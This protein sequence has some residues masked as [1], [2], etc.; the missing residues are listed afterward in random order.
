MT[1]V[2]YDRAV[3]I[4]QLV[5]VTLPYVDFCPF[6]VYYY[7]SKHLN[8]AHTL[9]CTYQPSCRHLRKSRWLWAKKTSFGFLMKNNVS[10]HEEEGIFVSPFGVVIESLYYV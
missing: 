3:R 8:Y 10:I 7:S 4:L 5:S 9:A 1:G 2:S 6:V